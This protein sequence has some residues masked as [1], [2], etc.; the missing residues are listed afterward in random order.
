[1]DETRETDSDRYGPAAWGA[2]LRRAAAWLTCLPLGAP[3]PAGADDTSVPA[4]EPVPTMPARAFRAFPLVGAALGL[5]AGAVYVVADGFGLPPLAA[6][7]IAVAVLAAVGCARFERGLA[8]VADGL[9]ESEV[10]ARLQRIAADRLGAAGGL[11]LIL[12]VALRAGALAALATPGAAAGAL[13]GA[14]AASRGAIALLV[15][16]VDSLPP[17]D[18]ADDADTAV[19]NPAFLPERPG[20]EAITLAAILSLLFALMF[21]GLTAG[22][23]ALAV[24]L[25]VLAALAGLLRRRLGGVDRAALGAVQQ[26]VE[27][28]M[29]LAYAAVA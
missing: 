19:S 15:H 20:G 24:G 23:V 6:G 18:D 4:G 12:S 26:A 11:A 16:R 27:T 5:A 8:A 29:L 25:T 10:A 7:L 1:M 14:A 9:G 21:P 13:L 3:A 28:A 2:D 22:L 17:V